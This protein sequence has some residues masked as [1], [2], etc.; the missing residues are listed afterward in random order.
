MGWGRALGRC[1]HHPDIAITTDQKLGSRRNK[2]IG[3]FFDRAFR[4]RLGQ[5]FTV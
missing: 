2:K 1:D 3:P 4:P 5:K